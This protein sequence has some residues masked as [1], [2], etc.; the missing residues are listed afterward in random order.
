MNPIT[1][2]AHRLM[3]VAAGI[4]MLAGVPSID[5]NPTDNGSVSVDISMTGSYAHADI[6]SL[7]ACGNETVTGEIAKHGVQHCNWWQLGIIILTLAA[8]IAAAIAAGL[9]ITA[10]S[11][12]AAAVSTATFLSF[13]VAEWSLI[14]AAYGG[15][16]A[17]YAL[18]QWICNVNKNNICNE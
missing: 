8:A 14:A 16:A 10:A 7:H 3:L 5:V 1:K 2:L 15:F 4:L 17:L 13:T 18:F 11:G 9:A 12:G 6:R